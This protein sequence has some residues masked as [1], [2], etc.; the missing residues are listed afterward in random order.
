MTLKSQLWISY[1]DVL[2]LSN[3]NFLQEAAWPWVQ[4]PVLL[5]LPLRSP[6]ACSASRIMPAQSTAMAEF[7]G[8]IRWNLIRGS[9]RL[10]TAPLS[11]RTLRWWPSLR[12]FSLACIYSILC[13]SLK[14]YL[15]VTMLVFW[16]RSWIPFHL[17]TVVFAVTSFSINVVFTRLS[18]VMYLQGAS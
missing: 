17:R 10:L 7:R 13:L 4:I 14:F 6:E 12:Y 3:L 5:F 16:V 8:S 11:K 1:L 18:A 2:I 15:V 9:E